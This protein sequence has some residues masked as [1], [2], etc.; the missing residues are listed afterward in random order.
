MITKKIWMFWHDSDFPLL[1]RKCME[2]IKRLHPDYDITIMSLDTYQNYTG[3]PPTQFKDLAI[4]FKSD[5]IRTK[6]VSEYGGFWIDASIYIN[7][8]LHE[9][10]DVTCDLYGMRQPSCHNQI[11]N[12]FFYSPQESTIV[13]RWL[14]E[15]ESAIKMGSNK[16]VEETLKQNH[17]TLDKDYCGGTYLFHQLCL[18]NVISKHDYQVI[19][20]NYGFNYK[21]FNGNLTLVKNTCLTPNQFTDPLHKFRGHE[22]H[23][24]Q[25]YYDKVGFIHPQSIAGELNIGTNYGSVCSLALFFAIICVVTVV[26]I[27]RK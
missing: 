18:M 15:Y 8:P 6:V 3:P 10:V 7:R 5:W 21:P 16:Y 4:Q 17:W 19:V 23:K 22:R 25:T 13:N 26:E 2:N 11:E 24:F 27:H 12:W 20:K 14:Q 1:V 9:W